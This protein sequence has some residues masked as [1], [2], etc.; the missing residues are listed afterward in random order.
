MKN[1][2]IVLIDFS[3]HSEQLLRFAYDWS[4]RADAVLLTFHNTMALSPLMTPYETKTILT[5]RA[6]YQAWEQLRAFTETVLPGA[7]SIQHLVSEKNLVVALRELLK[8]PFHHLVFLGIKGTGLLKK[9]FIGSQAVN[10]I[11]GIDSLIV[12]MPQHAPCCAPDAI[13]VAVQ[14]TYPLNLIELNKIIRLNGAVGSKIIFFSV[15]T[16]EDDREA[17]ERYL[18]ELSALYSDKKEAAY[19]LYSGDESWR[20]LKKII[21][22][23][24]NEFIVV[25]RGSRMFLDQIA[26][27]FLIN[28]L[29]YEGHTTLIIMP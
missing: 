20:D 14:K 26:R 2:F 16:P 8:K 21:K 10:V 7:T 15:V 23:K 11:D 27:K 6:N 13:H 12:A 17:T 19:E 24:Q 18:K 29:V 25:Q 1:R 28:D 9:I 4:K 22:G 3:P 5:E